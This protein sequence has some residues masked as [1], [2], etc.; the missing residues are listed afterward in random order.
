M[1]PKTS[2][3]KP[4][5]IARGWFVADA[6]GKVLGRLARD[7]AVVLQGKHKPTVSEHT[8]CGDSVVVINCEKVAVTGRKSEQKTYVHVTGYP[9]GRVEEDYEVVRDRHPE[10]ILIK[11][12]QRMLP[13]NRLGRQMLKQLFVYAGEEHPHGAQKPDGLPKL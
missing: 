7:I 9:S 8:Q 13:K 5:E 6:E 10:R 11:A 12:V 1:R 2:H 3:L 4:A